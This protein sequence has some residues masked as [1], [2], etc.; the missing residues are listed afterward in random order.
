LEGTEE[1]E[2]GRYELGISTGEASDDGLSF[3]KNL[4][5]SRTGNE[6]LSEGIE[7]CDSSG[8]SSWETV[9]LS[10]GPSLRVDEINERGEFTTFLVSF[11]FFVTLGEPDESGESSDT[12]FASL[13]LV[14][15]SIILSDDNVLFV[16]EGLSKLLPLG[17]KLFAVTTP[18]S[19]ELDENI[20]VR[21]EDDLIEIVVVKYEH[22]RGCLLDTTLQTSLPVD[23]RDD[24]ISSSASTVGLRIF[25]ATLREPL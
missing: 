24:V 7:R 21:V 5:A 8:I 6:L 14:F 10:A 15:I 2:K 3:L 4:S 20:L 13:S 19:V 22:L 11:S 1:Q 12:V 9:N 18:G 16:S 17:G 25:R 23:E